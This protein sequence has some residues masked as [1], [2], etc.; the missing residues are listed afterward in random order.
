MSVGVGFGSITVS[1]PSV[2]RRRSCVE[3]KEPRM[4]EGLIN[5]LN[6]L[7]WRGKTLSL[8]NSYFF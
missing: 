5:G 2:N 1:N 6:K 4:S 8:S 3:N 7:I